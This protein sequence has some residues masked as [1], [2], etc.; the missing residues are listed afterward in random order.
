M[1]KIFIGVAILV[2]IVVT[3]VLWQP[4]TE[5]PVVEREDPI[6]VVFDFYNPWLQA[7]VSTTT[8]PRA[9][10]LTTAPVL[11]VAVRDYIANAHAVVDPV[12]CQT[13]IPTKLGVRP[14]Y[15]NDATAE[16][17]VLS[18][19]N[20]DRSSD[21]A[22]VQLEVVDAAWQITNISCQSGESAPEKEFSFTQTGYLLK[23]VPPPLDDSRW[24]LVFAQGADLDQTVPLFF[25][26]TSTCVAL[27]G[28][29]TTC[30]TDSFTEA[31]R[32]TV[33][34]NMVEAGVQVQRLEREALR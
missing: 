5:T 6:D 25:T 15:A 20:D 4:D 26:A 33:I 10:G 32:A 7:V 11:A 12:L 18:R 2:A 34:G 14:V 3:L 22:L 1:K 13:N 27:D 17:Q 21:Y 24:H 31:R 16:L 8:D 19:F 9:A 29:E 28:A 23:S 30:S